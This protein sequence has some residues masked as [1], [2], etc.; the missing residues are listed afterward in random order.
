[1]L[2]AAQGIFLLFIYFSFPIVLYFICIRFG[3]N[4]FR[5]SVESFTVISCFLFGYIGI[6]AL[7]FGLDSYRITSGVVDRSVISTLF[8]CSMWSIF[9]LC[10]GFITAKQ[11]LP[12]KAN[13][14]SVLLIGRG[15]FLSL[16]VILLFCIGVL[17]AYLSKVQNIA[18][19]TLLSGETGAASDR[20]AMTATF[21]SNYH[22]YSVIFEQVILFLSM[23]F[24]ANFLVR[25]SISSFLIFTISFFVLTFASVMSAQKGPLVWSFISLYLVFLYVGQN[26]RYITKYLFLLFSVSLFTIVSLYLFIS[27][28]P[29]IFSALARV[30][31]RTLTG[32]IVPAYFYLQFFP[33]YSDF[34]FG[35]TAPNPGG[36]LGFSPFHLTREVMNWVNPGLRAEGIVG[37]APT[38]F[39][40]EAYAN[41]GFFGVAIIPF[42]VG[43]WVAFVAGL[44]RL[45]PKTPITIGFS[46]WMCMHFR[47][48][49][50]TGFSKFV[51]DFD[52]VV[53]GLSV[54]AVLLLGRIFSQSGRIFRELAHQ[55]EP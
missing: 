36:L 12:P 13:D 15:K 10:V 40:G 5:V 21:G 31:S 26:G 43:V 1:M 37:S 48:L 17:A 11:L 25:K 46:V 45:L 52:L 23:T 24:F 3:I 28:A 18:I 33:T 30:A 54:L 49:A 16:T 27:D 20:S 42:F 32:Q 9:T 35:T 19:F 50:S 2:E 38:M 22:R 6:P 29:G 7:F 53:V 14:E 39:W 41:F 51:L 8:L 47:Q 55:K 34:A 44:V 4:L